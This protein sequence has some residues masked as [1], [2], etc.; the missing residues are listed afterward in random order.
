MANNNSYKERRQEIAEKFD[1]TDTEILDR[2]ME[3]VHNFDSMDKTEFDQKYQKYKDLLKK[4]IDE[5]TRI[6][7]YK[8]SGKYDPLFRP[9]R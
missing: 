4:I 5:E 9:V 2:V 1:I 6:E 3:M 7:E 8:R